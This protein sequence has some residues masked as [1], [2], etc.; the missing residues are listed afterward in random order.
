MTTNSSC[1]YIKIFQFQLIIGEH[2]NWMF[3]LNYKS[4]LIL[5][6]NIN[7][8][9]KY[10]SIN[11]VRPQLWSMHFKRFWHNTELILLGDNDI[12]IFFYYNFM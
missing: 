2:E 12:L 4:I 8:S 5:C 6:I 3:L 11:Y 10:S 7:P 9:Y 1:T